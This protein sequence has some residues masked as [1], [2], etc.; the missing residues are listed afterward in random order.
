MMD[1][2]RRFDGTQ[3]FPDVSYAEFAVPYRHL[4]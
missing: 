3:Q 2:N 4:Y 1:G